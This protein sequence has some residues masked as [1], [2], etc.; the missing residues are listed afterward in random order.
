MIDSLVDLLL[1]ILL[2]YVFFGC[3]DARVAIEQAVKNANCKDGSFLFTEPASN[4]VGCYKFFNDLKN[5][6]Q[7]FTSCYDCTTGFCGQLVA[8]RTQQEQQFVAKLAM[9]SNGASQR[10]W[11]SGR[12][13]NAGAWLWDSYAIGIKFQVPWI[14]D[15]SLTVESEPARTASSFKNSFILAGKGTPYDWDFVSLA[16]SADTNNYVCRKDGNNENSM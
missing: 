5:W 16:Q 4:L 2:I 7:A 15:G 8:I 10:Y 3:L 1:F 13:N 6:T 14:T 9:A 11:T 12:S